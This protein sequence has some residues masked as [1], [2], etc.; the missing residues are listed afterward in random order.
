[1]NA[2]EQTQSISGLGDVLFVIGKWKKFIGVSV[3][4]VTVV[5][6]IISFLLPTLYRSTAVILP[7]KNQDVIGMLASSAASLSRSIDP[8]RM[9][10]A[11]RT[12]A[13]FYRYLAI[14]KSR[15]LLERTVKEFDLA[16]VYGIPPN[17]S[18]KAVEEL[19]SNINLRANEEGT[20]SIE[21]ID[22]DSARVA[23]MARF[24]VA[25][26][27][28]INQ[29]LGTTEARGNREFLEQ[30][31]ADNLREM[32]KTEDSL[33]EFQQQHGFVVPSDKP[34]EGISAVAELYVRKTLKELEIGLLKKTVGKNDPRLTI[35]QMELFEI[36]K[37]LEDVPELGVTYLRLYRDFAVQQRV[38][39]TI[40]PILEQARIEEQRD[41]PT[42][43]VLDYPDV[44]KIPFSPKKRIIVLVFFVLS[45]IVSTAV[46]LIRENLQ[47]M[48]IGRPDEYETLVRGWNELTRWIRVRR[49]TESGGD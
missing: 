49:R 11:G 34:T 27:D 19:E 22:R 7:P 10:G 42:L 17:E 3:M 4:S 25:E 12:S 26:L 16:E 28:R 33:K 36:D 21:L 46:A 41:T 1:M 48:K 39:E 43:L 2:E 8:L 30:R 18:Y 20:L 5:T 9:L 45:L 24:V 14:V 40:I 47:R 31:V 29:Q 38:Y 44:P 32:R 15:T 6:A 35:A 23:L 13:D 37:K